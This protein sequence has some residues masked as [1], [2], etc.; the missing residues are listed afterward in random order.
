MFTAALFLL[1]KFVKMCKSAKPV[2]AVD[3]KVDNT[4]DQE[5]GV[6]L[7]V[8][9]FHQKN[10]VLSM[11]IMLAAAI[12]ALYLFNRF[13]K[14]RLCNK[15]DMD[16]RNQVIELQKALEARPTVPG[17]VIVNGREMGPLPLNPA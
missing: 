12:L 6:H 3:V 4:I 2:T 7:A 9:D 17:G 5:G 15:P 10:S 14:K 13:C 8:L 11:L 1:T 16:T